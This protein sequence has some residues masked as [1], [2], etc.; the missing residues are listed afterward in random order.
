MKRFQPQGFPFP[1]AKKRVMAGAV[2]IAILLLISIVFITARPIPPPITVRHVKSVQSGNLVTATF[3]IANHTGGN[4]FVYPIS[5]EVSNGLAW[6]ACF[7][8]NSQSF[9]I[10]G[11]GPHLSESR[12]FYMTHLP[13]GS[14]LR[15]RLTG[16]KGLVGLDSFFM[17][18]NSRFRQ[19]QKS[20]SLNPFD[21]TMVFLNPIQVVSD[22]FV[23]SEPNS[24]GKG[25][26]EK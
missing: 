6:K 21:K 23:E 8:W 4:C 24:V 9:P 1:M 19:G 17:R 5:V 3:E 12:T 14:P 26:S 10:D 18:L 15:L 11:L 2:V 7:D 16:Q 22:E 13:T 25:V 20:V